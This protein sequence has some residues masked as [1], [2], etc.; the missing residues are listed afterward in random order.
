MMRV[1]LSW[2]SSSSLV[3]GFQQISRYFCLSLMKPNYFLD[4]KCISFG[5]RRQISRRYVPERRINNEGHLL[6]PREVQANKLIQCHRS[7]GAIEQEERLRKQKQ[8][9]DLNFSTAV[10]KLCDTL[11]NLLIQPHAQPTLYSKDVILRDEVTGF[12]VQGLRSYN[13]V[14]TTFSKTSKVFLSDVELE[15][16]SLR[17][18][19][20]EKSVKWRSSE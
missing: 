13:I 2:G 7:P 19:N 18:N 20:S 12:C 10:Q 5:N 6:V 1:V 16:L 17:S 11:P 9:S 8:K 14:M 3:R 15:T 4:E